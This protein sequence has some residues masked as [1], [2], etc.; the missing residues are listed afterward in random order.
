VTFIY[1]LLGVLHVELFNFSKLPYYISL[2]GVVLS[3]YGIFLWVRDVI[4]ESTYLRRVSLR[5]EYSLR[6]AMILFIISE[7]MFFFAFF[8]AFFHSSLSPSIEIG[9]VWPPKYIGA[10]D[11]LD[12]PLLNTLILL[13]S[14]AT[15][16]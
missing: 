5:L 16:T 1:G 15:I 9:S 6:Y 3:L 14:G 2:I 8:W 13:L 11:Y 10:L 12:I 7:I 4:R